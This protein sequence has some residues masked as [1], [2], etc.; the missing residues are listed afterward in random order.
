V[1]VDDVVFLSATYNVGAVALKLDPAGLQEIW[2]DELA[3]QNHWAT[4]L[5]LDGFLY[6]MDG[7]HERGSN[8]RC[9]EFNTGKVRWTADQGLGR[10][11]FIL[12]EGHLIGV[13]ER[14]DIALIEASPEGYKEK[15][16]ARALRYPVW[17]PPILAQGLLY[18]R[19]ERTY[20]S[21]KCLDL[22]A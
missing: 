10:A 7:R 6:G 9:I 13:S 15:A 17:T 1:L 8:L 11:S 21:I 12:A 22:R 4:S 3:M 16:R 19:N 14:G 18:V 20:R 2:R 5:Y